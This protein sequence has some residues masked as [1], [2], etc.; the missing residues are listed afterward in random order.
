[1]REC[2]C[3]FLD[4]GIGKTAQINYHR[5]FNDVDSVYKTK[6]RDSKRTLYYIVD[7]AICLP[8]YIVYY[9]YYPSHVNNFNL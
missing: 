6:N 7:N 8:E 9:E 1:M 4:L 2:T 3:L 5:H